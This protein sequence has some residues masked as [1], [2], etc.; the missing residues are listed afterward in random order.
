[1][2]RVRVGVVGSGGIFQGA[3]LPAYPDIAEAQLAAICDISES[4]LKAAER[5]ARGV[6]QE[7]MQKAKDEGNIDL[8]ERLRE[9][10]DN[11]KTYTSFSEMLSKENLDLVDICT[12]TKFHAPVAIEA[13]KNG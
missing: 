6:Y 10:I 5:R 4:V 13:L 11:L 12:P 8:A 2:K 7:R 1:M 9:D 3:H